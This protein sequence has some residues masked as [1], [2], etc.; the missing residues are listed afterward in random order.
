MECVKVLERFGPTRT[1]VVVPIIAN[2][3]SPVDALGPWISSSARS[4]VRGQSTFLTILHSLLRICTLPD[5]FSLLQIN[6]IN[7]FMS[8]FEITYWLI[9]SPFRRMVSGGFVAVLSYFVS[10]LIQLK[11]NVCPFFCIF[12]AFTLNFFL[13]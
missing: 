2:G 1:I 13:I 11:V 8:F 4:N 7:F 9:C 12:I 10:V 3:L 6:V 5:N